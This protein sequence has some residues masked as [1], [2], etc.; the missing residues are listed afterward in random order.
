MQSW[1]CG[2]KNRAI[3]YGIK[4]HMVVTNKGWPIE[5]CLR[6][7]SENDIRLFLEYHLKIILREV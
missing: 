4:V 2:I 6:P 7:A 1:F 3:F 5:V